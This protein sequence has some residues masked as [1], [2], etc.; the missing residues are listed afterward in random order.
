[1][2]GGYVRLAA[3][4]CE[5]DEAIWK[6]GILVRL[7][8]FVHNYFRTRLADDRQQRAVEAIALVQKVGYAEGVGE[9]LDALCGFTGQPRQEILDIVKAIKDSPGFI[10]QQP[11]SVRH[12]GDCCRRCIPASVGEVV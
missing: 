5:H 2:A 9:E 8:A 12:A 7:F 10:A 3:D 6:Q 4:M 11:G 1:M